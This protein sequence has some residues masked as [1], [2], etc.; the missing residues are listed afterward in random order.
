MRTGFALGLRT[1]AREWRAGDLAVLFLALFVAVAALTGVGFLVDRID[2]AMRLQ[3]SE[4]LAADLRLQ[5]PDPITAGHEAEARRRGLATSEVISTLSVV[6]KDELTQL[7]NIHAVTAG[8]PLRGKV[9]VAD[10][11]FGA[12]RLADDIPAPGEA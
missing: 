8:Y 3:A 9:R 5:S 6:L 12:T 10:Q 4:V 1:L 2:R 11:P 7:S